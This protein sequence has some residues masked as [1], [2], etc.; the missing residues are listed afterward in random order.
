MSAFSKEYEIY[1][2]QI[3]QQGEASPV[4][5]LDFLEDVAIAHS[6]AVGMGIDYLTSLRTCWVL[7]RW[8]L[9]MESYPSL[10]EKIKV[11]TY[12]IDFQRFYGKRNFIIWDSQGKI[13]GKARS[14]WIYLNID[15]RRP[16]RIPD[17]FA[18]Q[19]GVAELLEE[20]KELLDQTFL[21]K[22][23]FEDLPELTVTDSELLFH[24]RRS[25]IDT[26]GHVNNTRYV[27]WM[28]EGIGEDI[29]KEY[30]LRKLEVVYKKETKYGTDIISQTQSIKGLEPE[31]L[32]RIQD[33][34]GQ[35]L[36]IGRTI[37]SKPEILA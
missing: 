12:A 32:H 13:I 17:H 25:D 11:D 7:N 2:F 23:S 24:V 9:E 26:N 33:Q 30:K 35:D 28:L 31:Y 27:E 3:N 18:S 5:I 14:L 16:V 19:Y 10:G 36:A 22:D 20:N 6:K 15:K 1:Y 4:T 8:E 21:G 37:W 34:Q 29:L